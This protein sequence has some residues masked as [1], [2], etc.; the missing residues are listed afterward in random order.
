MNQDDCSRPSKENPS[1]R[2]MSSAAKRKE[3][4]MLRSL[5]K[6]MT[7]SQR[8]SLAQ[9]LRWLRQAGGL[10]NPSG[11]LPRGVEIGWRE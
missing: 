7:K 1:E 11:A 4:R 10:G 3:A 5:K 2:D 6:H 9:M 8:Q